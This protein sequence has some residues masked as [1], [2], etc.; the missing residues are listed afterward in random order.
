MISEPSDVVYTA[1]VGDYES[2]MEV[3]TELMVASRAKFVCFTDSPTLTS[4]TWTIVR[5]DRK[6]AADPIRSARAI[7]ITGHPALDEY[8]R[9]L[10]VDNRI[11][12]RALPETILDNWL[13]SSS[14]AF[15]THS[16]RVTVA[17][18]FRAVLHSRLDDR[19]RVREQFEHYATLASSSLGDRPLWTAL[20]ARRNDSNVRS[21]AQRWLQEVTRYS[22]RDQLSV[23]QAL[24]DQPVSWAE[25]PLDNSESDVH[26]WRNQTEIRRSGRAGQR[27]GSARRELL[28]LLGDELD[29]KKAG[30][31]ATA[32]FDRCGLYT[33]LVHASGHGGGSGDDAPKAELFGLAYDRLNL[34]EAVQ[35]VRYSAQSGS[36]H[37]VVT[38]NVDH[39]TRFQ[40][41]PGFRKL[42]ELAS[43]VLLD[44]VPLVWAARLQGDR[45]ATR[46]TGVDLLHQ[47]LTD[48]DRRET[49]FF[50]IGG[51]LGASPNVLRDALGLKYGSPHGIT[52]IN[53]TPQD[54]LRE[55]YV[56]SI[57]R[58]LA[59]ADPKVVVIAIGSPKQEELYAKLID[60]GAGAGCYL[61]L[62]A[63]PQFLAGSLRR[64]PLFVQKLGLEWAFRLISE[65]KRLLRRYTRNAIEFAPFF[66]PVCCLC[67]ARASGGDFDSFRVAA[68]SSIA[69]SAASRPRP[70]H[71]RRHSLCSF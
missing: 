30:R 46:V 39:F 71:G 58:I 66:S 41:D 33:R 32:L 20:V 5:I 43:L 23:R 6:F 34:R 35:F 18:E 55:E 16:F 26:R 36:A 50:V 60:A 10:W 51:A 24:N 1:V 59:S 8:A 52:V 9:W 54:L 4:S 64:A 61:G 42:Y 44:G 12:L 70:G 48:F 38:P 63:A 13:K 31:L 40:R 29:A 68:P 11:E 65:P 21:F 19:G 53:P 45:V 25:I 27:E 67:P 28:T 15:P 62:G 56:V 49:P 69:P 37:L 57:A 2:L 22:R 3:P 14:I 47:L 7:K 17:E